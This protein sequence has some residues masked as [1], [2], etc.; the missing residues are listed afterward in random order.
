MGRAYLLREVFEGPDESEDELLFVQDCF[1]LFDRDGI[2]DCA[3][4]LLL[5]LAENEAVLKV[6]VE[7]A[8]A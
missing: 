1:F 8:G 2:D 4:G 5:G 3:F 7:E 6:G